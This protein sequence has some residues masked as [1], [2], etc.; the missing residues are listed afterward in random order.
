MITSHTLRAMRVVL[1]PVVATCLLSACGEEDSLFDSASAKAAEAE[2]QT[3]SVN[4]SEPE[5]NVDNSVQAPAEQ[6]AE[7]VVSAPTPSVQQ[8]VEPPVVDSSGDPSVTLTVQSIA[9]ASTASLRWSSENVD[10]CEA[11]GAWDGDRPRAGNDQVELSETGDHT[12]LM[13]CQGGQGSAVAMV[14]VSLDG[15]EVAWVAPAQNTDGSDLTDLAG[16]NLY[17]GENSGDYTEVL[18]VDDAS[19]TSVSLPIEPG[20]YYMAMTAYDLEGNE[21]DLS[22]EILQVIN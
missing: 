21:S 20:E 11:T 7:Q 19:L 9:N 8:P 10:S 14:T 18:S 2:Q 4:N 5:F 12:F 16:Y 17:Y 6:P 1:A 22:N 3:E 13:T 15:T